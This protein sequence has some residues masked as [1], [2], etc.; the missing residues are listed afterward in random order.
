MSIFYRQKSI[1]L[2]LRITGFVAPK[3]LERGGWL[4]LRQNYFVKTRV[5]WS[6]GM[7]SPI[8]TA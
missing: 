5:V 4:P 7:T 8:A 6:L 3:T 2:H 1:L